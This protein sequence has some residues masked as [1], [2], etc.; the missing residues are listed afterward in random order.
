MYDRQTLPNLPK[1]APEGLPSHGKAPLRTLCARA[2]MDVPTTAANVRKACAGGC[3]KSC[4]ARG[5]EQ[6][7]V[8]A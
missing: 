8:T 7:G 1:L 5:V 3:G 4:A 2:S 6:Q